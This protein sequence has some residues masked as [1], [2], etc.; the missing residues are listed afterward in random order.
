MQISDCLWQP[1]RS[2]FAGT[3]LYLS[4]FAGVRLR[5][6]LGPPH[7]YARSSFTPWSPVMAE[8]EMLT[9]TALK[10][11][12]AAATAGIIFS[13]L[14]LIIFWLLRVSVPVDPMDHG[15]WLRT[16]SHT[17]AGALNLVPF[18]G[19]AFLWFIG[20]LRDRL[21]ERE[22]RFFATV[23]FGSAMLFLAM[24]FAAA[25]VAGALVLAFAAQPN[26]LITSPSFHFARAVAY[27]LM[28]VYAIKAAGVFMFSTSTVAIYT[29]FAP[30][31]IALL[32]YALALIL[33][34]G[35]YY[36]TWGFVVLPIWVFMIS[37]YILT[38]ALRRPTQ[39][40]QGAPE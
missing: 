19:I 27:N 15:A 37:V 30:R 35:S 24:L 25:A 7:D 39:V 32:G 26:E 3:L 28:N 1:I 10:T 12:R 18:A 5:P 16:N 38:D 14:L 29:G 2:V 22:D 4:L 23:F 9:R 34:F 13:I 17:V 36:I 21:G 8:K 40:Q 31:W 6:V 20:V 11:P 33:L